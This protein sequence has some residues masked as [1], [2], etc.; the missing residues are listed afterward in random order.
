MPE[1]DPLVEIIR[2]KF[3]G[4]VT[5]RDAAA[6]RVFL[7]RAGYVIARE[8]DLTRRMDALTGIVSE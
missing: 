2:E 7:Y 4:N 6:L 3:F 8:I 1:C 5:E